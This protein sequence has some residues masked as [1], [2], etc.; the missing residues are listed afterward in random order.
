M[1]RV[2]RL[3]R[4]LD[5]SE[6]RR[7]LRDDRRRRHADHHQSRPDVH[8]VTLPIGQM[9]HVAVDNQVPYYI[10]SNMQDDGTM[11]GPSTSPEAVANNAARAGGPAAAAAAVAVAAAAARRCRGSTRSAAANPASPS[12]TP[13]D[14]DIV[15]A[16]CYGN[17]V[18]RYDARHG[19]RAIGQPVDDHARLAAERTPSIAAT[20]RRRWRS[21]RSTRT[22]CYYGCQVILRDHQRR[23][24]LEEFSPDLSHQGSQPDRLVRR[25]RRRQPRA[26]LWRGGVCASRRRRSSAG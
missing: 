24:E 3:P 12:P 19:H 6:E 20:G 1:G 2:R 10:Y 25:H 22:R 7:S 8:R 17:K 23:P 14:A 5:R 26:V 11:R 13:T 9:Y 18:T 21:I 4:H 16:S 15:W